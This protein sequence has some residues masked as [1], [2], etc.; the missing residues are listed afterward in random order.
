MQDHNLDCQCCGGQTASDAYC[1]QCHHQYNEWCARGDGKCINCGS[2]VDNEGK[3]NRCGHVRTRDDAPVH[4][5]TNCAYCGFML[6]VD[7]T[8]IR[9]KSHGQPTRTL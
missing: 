8:C 1:L 6:D 7:G 4:K 3:C 2:M 9:N 5:P